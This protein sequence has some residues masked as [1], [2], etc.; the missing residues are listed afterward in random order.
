MPVIDGAIHHS[1]SPVRGP[2]TMAFSYPQL[3]HDGIDHLHHSDDRGSPFATLTDQG[4][5]AK[6]TVD[7]NASYWW[8]HSPFLLTIAGSVFLGEVGR[9][10]SLLLL[11][12]YALL[13][14]PFG[15]C[16]IFI[17]PRDLVTSDSL[18]HFARTTMFTVLY[19]K[20]TDHLQDLHIFNTLF[21]L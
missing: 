7:Y 2:F 15:L 13:Y 4:K 12:Q 16:Q 10:N 5:F 9:L 17:L 19:L 11:A 14:S 8:H 21:S 6:G 1:C 20:L 3:Q 18:A